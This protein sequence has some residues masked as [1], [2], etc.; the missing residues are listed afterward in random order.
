MHGCDNLNYKSN[1]NRIVW[2]PHQQYYMCTNIVQSLYKRTEK[3]PLERMENC[4]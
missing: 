4:K 2:I 1:S 3:T